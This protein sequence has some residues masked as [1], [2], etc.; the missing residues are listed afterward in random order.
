VWSY[1]EQA[2]WRTATETQPATR[3][4][5]PSSFGR[6]R[7]VERVAAEVFK[8]TS[9]SQDV[10]VVTREPGRGCWTEEP[11]GYKPGESQNLDFPFVAS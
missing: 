4:T 5:F 3:R 2:A 6:A 10:V 11:P 8:K 1:E 7:E 9:K